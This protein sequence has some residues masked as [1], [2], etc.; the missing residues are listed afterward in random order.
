MKHFLVVLLLTGWALGQQ[1]TARVQEQSARTAV[2][3]MPSAD[4]LSEL[5]KKAEDKVAAFQNAV[6]AA[7]PQLDPLD[8]H[9][10][11]R[12]TDDASTAEKILA[13]MKSKGASGYGLMMLL[14]AL[15]TLTLDATDANMRLLVHNTAANKLSDTATMLPMTS[16]KTALDGCNDISELLLHASLRYIAGEEALL[17]LYLEGGPPKPAR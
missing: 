12:Y 11:A 6:S 10:A 8:T 4:E 17:K 7:K 16:L 13:A 3:N 14:D 2:N 9:L 1:S 15:D 5:F